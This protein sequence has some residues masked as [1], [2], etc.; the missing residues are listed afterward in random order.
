MIKLYLQTLYVKVCSLLIIIS[1]SACK[2]YTNETNTSQTQSVEPV[3]TKIKPIVF[4]IKDIHDLK[5]YNNKFERNKLEAKCYI[6]SNQ[7]LE[8]KKLNAD[9][10]CIVN[11]LDI[12]LSPQDIKFIKETLLADTTVPINSEM[13]L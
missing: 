5:N 11:Y 9:Q 7:D 13:P 6:F 10:F 12:Q 4:L 2:L 3:M 8:N 1:L